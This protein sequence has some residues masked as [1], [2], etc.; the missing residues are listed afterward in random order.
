[1]TGQPV[2]T[3]LLRQLRRAKDRMD[4]D[5][6]TPLDLA[7]VAAVAGYSRYHFGRRFRAVYGE[8]PGQYLTRRRV[9]R[10]QDLLCSANLTV[11][12]ICLLVGFTSLGTFCNRFKQQVGMTPTEFR[13][14]ARR[15]GPAPVPGCFVLCWAGGFR[16][17]PA[18]PDQPA[19]A[20]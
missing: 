7:S 8:T 11:T 6:S 10:S 17:A 20:G 9:E 18:G 13:A 15:T 12:E 19:T 5:W 2:D 4:R 3:R 14:Q 16:T 1:M